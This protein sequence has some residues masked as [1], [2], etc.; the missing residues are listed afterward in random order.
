MPRAPRTIKTGGFYHVLNRGNGGQR[1]FYKPGDYLAFCR[2]L[3]EALERYPVELLAWCL[4]PNHWHLVLR[5]TRP[6]AL[7][8]FMLWVGVTHARR[9][10]LHHGNRRGGHLYQGRFKSFP[11]QDDSHFRTVCRYVEANPKRAKQVT[12]AE[13]WPWS[14]LATPPKDVP[15]EEW[16]PL[17]K[18]PVARPAD[19]VQWVNEPLSDAE[20]VAVK[21]SIERGRPF[22]DEGWVNKT[23]KQQ[24]LMHTVRPRGR[25]RKKPQDEKEK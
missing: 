14:S 6:Q 17:A 18:W 23:V 20:I 12:R 19:W 9:H 13:R 11:I 24:G 10:H 3:A 1:I 16:P 25:P 2:V 5:P 15:A 4:M 22:G 8:R 7:S 21:T